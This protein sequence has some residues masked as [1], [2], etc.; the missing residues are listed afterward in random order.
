MT[1]PQIKL[2]NTLTREKQD[3]TP[4][5]ASNVGMYVCG[6]TPYDDSHIGHARVYVVFD[7]LYRL[8]RHVYG[9]NAVTYVRNFTDIDDKII[10]RAN[11][12][13]QHPSEVA[14]RNIASFYEDMDALNILRP[15]FEPRVSTSIAGIVQMTDELIDKGYAYVTAS[16][17][18]IYRTTKF[19]R[20]GQLARRKLDEQQHGARVGVDDEKES[21][22]DFVLWKANAKSTTKLE[23][24]F[25]PASYGAKH[26]TA[27]GRPGWHIECSVMSKQHLGPTF[28]IHGGGED[29]Q[30]PHHCCEIAQ[31]EALLPAGQRM[32]NY[33][34]HNGFITVNGTKMSKSL[35]NFT[36]IKQA[37]E[38][39]SPEAI[40]L[41]LLQT[42]YR[43]P[44]DFSDEALQAAEARWKRWK[45]AKLLNE[46]SEVFSEESF[47]PILDA[48]I[49][50][51]GD[52]LNTSHALAVLEM[53]SSGYFWKLASL[54]GFNE[55]PNVIRE[56]WGYTKIEFDM[57]NA[58]LT[59]RTNKN[60]AESDRL[61]DELKALGIEVK[62]TAEGQTWRRL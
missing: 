33:W 32:A 40:R 2:Y 15:N 22:N 21:P 49:D 3:F 26:F 58:R 12:L 46:K 55:P 47:K 41:W 59:A 54:L 29:L 4:I 34:L 14:E 1:T 30:F 36:T 17:D 35:G 60:F 37:L 56:E 6:V 8:L 62:D 25:E 20:F 28:D 44:V 52:D 13:G 43:K 57:L 24:A 5:D 10:T 51:L 23:Q 18:V 31:S 50:A 38:K 48:F 27:P 7:V 42:H 19:P 16:G 53:N 11:E 61:R 45:S 9:E 39:Y